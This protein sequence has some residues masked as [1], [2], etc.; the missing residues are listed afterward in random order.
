MTRTRGRPS[1]LT[2]ARIEVITK[3]VREGNYMKVAAEAAGVSVPTVYAW[4]ERGELTEEQEQDSIYAQFLEA[5]REAEAQSEQ[6]LVAAVQK[7]ATGYR[8]RKTVVRTYRDPV[9]GQ[10]VTETTVEEADVMDWRAAAW[11]LQFRHRSR[12]AAIPPPAAEGEVETVKVLILSKEPSTSAPEQDQKQLGGAEPTTM[13][14]AL[15]S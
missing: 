15:G 1:L 7:S 14:E 4:M 6:I 10:E 13:G 8:K 9:T 11:M 5:V 3:L 2:P 12:W